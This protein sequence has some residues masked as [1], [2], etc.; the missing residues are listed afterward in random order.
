MDLKTRDFSMLGYIMAITEYL[1]DTEDKKLRW[2]VKK[3]NE[4]ARDIAAVYK[5][6][7]MGNLITPRKVKQIEKKV[8]DLTV[9]LPR[10]GDCKTEKQKENLV[11][12]FSFILSILDEILRK[13]KNKPIVDMFD[14]LNKR[15]VWCNDY[16]DPKLDKFGCYVRGE[17]VFDEWIKG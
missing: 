8:S 7:G 16:V 6:D 5:G 12:N 17:H 13:S 15:I 14:V 2:R 10:V 4:A 3:V 1:L 9:K 11:I